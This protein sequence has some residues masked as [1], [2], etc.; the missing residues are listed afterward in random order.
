MLRARAFK[1]DRAVLQHLEDTIVDLRAQSTHTGAEIEAAEGEQARLR[2]EISSL[3]AELENLKARRAVAQTREEAG[4]IFDRS[5][6]DNAR[7]KVAELR[8]TIAEQNKR[9]DFYGRSAAAG[10]GPRADPRGPG[11]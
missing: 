5:T 4:Y 7:E 1:T 2:E 10:R 3:R 8:A 11:R 6:F 9:L